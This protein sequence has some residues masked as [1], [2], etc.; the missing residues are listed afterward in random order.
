MIVT[1][2]VEIVVTSAN[3][4]R[5]RRFGYSLPAFKDKILIK[6]EHLSDT[7]KEK[8][9][10]ICDTCHTKYVSRWEKYIKKKDKS[11]CRACASFATKTHEFVKQQFLLKGYALLTDHY[12]NAHQHLEY[13]CSKHP[14]TIQRIIY[15]SLQS[16]CGCRYCGI[17][18]RAAKRQLTAIKAK[19][20]T[21]TRGYTF[22]SILKNNGR[23]TSKSYVSY[24]C[25]NH[26]DIVQ[27][28]RCNNLQQGFGCP[29]CYEEKE[30]VFVFL[31]DGRTPIRDYLRQHMTAWKEKS[32]EACGHVC[33]V[34][35]SPNF[36]IHHHYPFDRMMNEAHLALNIT[37]REFAGDYHID[38]LKALICELLIYHE[39]RGLGVCLA[40]HLHR[41]LHSVYGYRDVIS[42]DK[43]D[44][45]VIRYKSRKLFF[46]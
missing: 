36:E 25:P 29:I 13:I 10:F 9:D 45:F 35:G 43:F 38:E 42:K 3:A 1:E 12:I 18:K 27:Q 16:G 31:K 33:I 28:M 39:L 44:D 19:E 7:S 40:A 37:K 2:T 21:E 11:I 30:K 6:P 4:D 41:K 8:I 14:D 26:P 17:E 15:N 23:I 22:V 32:S 5:L 46:Q 34:T 20:I 24:I